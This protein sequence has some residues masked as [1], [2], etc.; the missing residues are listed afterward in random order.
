MDGR[1]FLVGRIAWRQPVNARKEVRKVRKERIVDARDECRYGR[2]VPEGGGTSVDFVFI[3]GGSQNGLRGDWKDWS[4]FV[5]P[6]GILGVT[7][8]A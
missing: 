5:A 8:V 3:D 6:G 2:W 7:T 1:S 4:P